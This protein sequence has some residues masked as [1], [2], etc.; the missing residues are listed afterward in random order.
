MPPRRLPRGAPEPAPRRRASRAYIQYSARLARAIC[1]R[2]A[3]GEKLVAICA[4]ADMPSRGTVGRWVRELPRFKAIY[5]RAKAMGLRL[6]G[7][8]GSSYDPVAAHEIVVRVSQGET[9][10]AIADD[11]RMPPIWTI[12]Y[13]RQNEAGFGDALTLAREALADRYADLGWRMALAATPETTFL[14]RMQLAQ[15]RW[16]AAIQSPR[17]HG[18]LK[19]VEPPRPQEVHTYLFR[20]FQIEKNPETGQIRVV[21]YTPNGETMLPERT[22]EGPWGDPPHVIRARH[23]AA[24]TPTPGY[25]PDGHPLPKSE[26]QTPLPPPGPADDSDRWL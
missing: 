14:T 2:V 24:G 20:H 15:L 5:D 16:T 26:P 18:K 4:D 11:P 8:V 6:G 21:C 19:P 22:S 1:A 23:Y 3:A 17:T 13:W 12:M 25:G 10:T 7:G 9:L